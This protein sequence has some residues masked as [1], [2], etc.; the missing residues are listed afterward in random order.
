MD[1]VEITEIAHLDSP[2][3]TWKN[4][5]IPDMVPVLM[6][7]DLTRQIGMARLTWTP[8]RTV[9]LDEMEV[10]VPGALKAVCKVEAMEDIGE[11]PM[12]QTALV[13]AKRYLD[14]DRQIAFVEGGSVVNVS[15]VSPLMQRE[16]FGQEVAEER[17]TQI[18][19]RFDV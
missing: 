16:I 19:D 5:T 1:F 13:N 15:V 12:L 3:A 11:Q 2:D 9:E 14:A 4:V 10:E 18:E 17:Q 8:P 6:D 7:F